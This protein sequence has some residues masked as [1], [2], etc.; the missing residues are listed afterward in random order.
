M[1]LQLVAPDSPKGGPRRRWRDLA[2]TDFK[3]V[4]LSDG[5]WYDKTLD[6]KQW[7]DMWKKKLVESHQPQPRGMR[8]MLCSEC[9][10]SF[11]REVNKARHKCRVERAKPVSEQVG[12]VQCKRWFRSKG[13]LAVHTCRREE[14][15][16]SEE[17]LTNTAA[18]DVIC[19]DVEGTSHGLE[20]SNDTSVY[21]NDR[22]Q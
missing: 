1:S 3:T 20:T 7:R 8:P 15:D 11:S 22:N 10:R 14:D 12:A 21:K 5:S 9:G 4:G 19:S 18:V 13:G 6:R 16:E 2:K 17:Q